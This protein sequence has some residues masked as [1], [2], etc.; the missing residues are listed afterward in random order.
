MNQ[1]LTTKAIYAVLLTS[2]C[3]N[4]YFQFFDGSRNTSKYPLLAKRLFVANPSDLI[5]NFTPLRSELRTYVGDKKERIGIYFEYLPTGT[6][7]NISGNEEFYRASL[8]KLPGVM[9]AMKLIEEGKL[10]ESD[11]LE[12]KSYHINTF[13]DGETKLSPGDKKTIGELIQLS[14]RESNNTAY[15]VLYERINGDILKKEKADEQVIDDVYDFL[16]VNRSESDQSLFISPK[17]YSSI[18]KSLYFSA[19]LSYENSSRILSYLTESTFNEWLPKPIPADR[20]QVAHKFGVFDLSEPAN[21][22]VNSDCGIVYLPQRPYA[23]CV[24]VQHQTGHEIGTHVREIS[25][26]VYD[27]MSTY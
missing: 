23:L 22:K 24:M 14:L 3:L 13:F 8:V 20:V 12:V 15:E 7:I 11:S 18:L 9:R 10:K 21:Y 16:D 25:R 6:S 26:L 5:I 4:I 27:Y 1:S 19:Y 2:I 17:S